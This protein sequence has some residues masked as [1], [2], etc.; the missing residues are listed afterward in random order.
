[1]SITQWETFLLEESYVLRW[2]DSIRTSFGPLLGEVGLLVGEEG[3][4]D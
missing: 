3:T 4:A 1:M 2:E